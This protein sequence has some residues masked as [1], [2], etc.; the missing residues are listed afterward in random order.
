L[1]VGGDAGDSDV[2][3]VSV[4]VILER[5]V[6]STW[7]LCKSGMLQIPILLSTLL[8]GIEYPGFKTASTSKASAAVFQ[9]PAG[10][11]SYAGDPGTP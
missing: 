7:S 6:S 3:G 9:S 4:G 2:R 11:T 10:Q 5:G 1:D 8:A